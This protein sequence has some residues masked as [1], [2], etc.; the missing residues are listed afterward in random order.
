[1]Q[2]GKRVRRL[3][4]AQLAANRQ[5]VKK[6][7]ELLDVNIDMDGGIG[8]NVDTRYDIPK[9]RK[10]TIN[11]YSFVRAHRGD[12]AITVCLPFDL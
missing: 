8:M 7:T 6:R 10:D 1:M 3:E 11:T 2:I 9:S 12:P 4:R 5:S